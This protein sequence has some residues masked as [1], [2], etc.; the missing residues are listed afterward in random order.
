M[1]H[2]LRNFSPCLI[3]V[4]L[5][6]LAIPFCADFAQEGRRAPNNRAPEG[7]VTDVPEY[8][9]NVILCR[10]TATSITFSIMW[11]ENKEAILD[12]NASSEQMMKSERRIS[13]KA[14]EPVQVR[15]D[16]LKPDTKYDYSILADNKRILPLEG[17]GSFHTARIPGS[18]FTFTISADSHLDSS[19][20]PE[21][22]LRTLA[23]A[24]SDN[25]DF[26][27][28]L[29]D[30]FMT[31]KHD[32]RESA[33]KQY[34]AQRYYFGKIGHSV[35]IFLALGNHD[36]EMLDRNGKTPADGLAVWSH[37]MRTR[38]F[39]NPVA[40]GFYTGNELRHPIAGLLE[41][42]YAWEWGDALFVVLDPY[43]T[44][45]PAR[46]GGNSWDLTIGRSQYEW[47]SCTLRKSKSRFK[48]VFIH[49][50]TGSNQ[51]GGRG[52]AEAAFYKEW[53]GHDVDGTD[54]FVK[55]RP[56]WEMPIHRLLIEAGVSAVFHGHD[57]FYARQE[58]EGITYQLVPQP[59]HQNERSHHATEY[60]YKEGLFLPSSGHLRVKIAPEKT[61]VEY[62]RNNSIAASYQISPPNK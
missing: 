3:S 41:N 24:L 18:A 10:P 30:T 25:P 52:G 59:A 27:I 32:S 11:H 4:F 45:S 12:W 6:T 44:S 36:G 8:S 49:Q 16:N 17:A 28:D 50:L 58:L 56:G 42:Y 39:A 2:A 5:L 53:G 23:A 31:E 47:L 57:H 14:N 37:R 60:G 13:L 29:G 35:P 7:F 22:Y 54:A 15:I 55:N 20:L 43:W 33:E 62:I 38:Y 9:G 26:H 61:T 1:K 40:D 51:D 46:K 21:L 48:F 34:W 19:C